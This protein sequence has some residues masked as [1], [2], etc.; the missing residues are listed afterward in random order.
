MVCHNFQKLGHYAREC[1]LPPVT[2]MYFHASDHETE[3]CPTLL[4][5][6]QEKRN[7]KNQN[8]QWISAKVRDE[9]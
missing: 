7:Q 4:G 1:P 5:N 8:V 2:C 3:E 6:I 9:G